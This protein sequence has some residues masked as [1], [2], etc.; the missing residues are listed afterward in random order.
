MFLFGLSEAVRIPSAVNADG[1]ILIQLTN[2]P[3]CLPTS[4][5]MALKAMLPVVFLLGAQICAAFR[6]SDPRRLIET[7]W[8]RLVGQ[9]KASHPPRPPHPQLYMLMAEELNLYRIFIDQLTFLVESA[10]N[11]SNRLSH[12]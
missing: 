7:G 8:Q 12:L 1:S 4:S 6:A 11:I 10:S 5:A 3:F 9:S 2:R